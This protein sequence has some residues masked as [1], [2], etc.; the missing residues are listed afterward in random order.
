MKI[1]SNVDC[2]Q[3]LMRELTDHITSVNPYAQSFKFMYNIMKM[4]PEKQQDI[5]MFIFND[6]ANDARRYNLP[7]MTDVAAIF[8]SSDGG[9]S[10]ADRH[11]IVEPFD[12]PVKTVSTLSGTLDPLAYPLLFP[13][14]DFGWHCGMQQN[15]PRTATQKKISQ[16]KYAA[17]R[18]SVRGETDNFHLSGKLFLQ[19][20]V[21]MYV[22]IEAER[23]SYIRYHQVQLRRD[24]YSNICD[25]V[26]NEAEQ[27]HCTIGR[28]VVLPSSF[29]GSPRNMNERYQDA[30]C[31]VRRHGKPDIFITFT[32]NPN[33]KEIQE[34][35]SANEA[36]NLR[37]DIVA[38]V[39]HAK[40]KALIDDVSKNRIFGTVAALIYTI[41]FQKRGL[42]HAHILIS[43]C[44]D[45][46][47]TD[48]ATIDKYVSAEVP[49]EGDPLREIVIAHM[50][51]GP[52]GTLGC[53]GRPAPCM[54]ENGECKKGYPRD[55]A[56]ESRQHTN[57]Y[58]VY[59]R[60][61]DG[62]S[63]VKYG[64]CLDNRWIVPH[65]RYLSLK[66]NA[67]INVEICTTVKSVKYIYK[68]IYKGYDACTVALEQRTVDCDEIQ[69]FLNAR[70]V[71]SVEAAWRIFEYEMHYQ[72]AIV[73]RLN[74]HLE[75]MQSEL[76]APG[77]EAEAL[78][79]VRDSKLIAWFKLN[80]H[81]LQAR[82][83]LYTEIP[84][85]YT[86]DNKNTK[87]NPRKLSIGQRVITRLY[88]VNPKNIELFYL[89][90]IL[91]YTAGA[92]SYE[93]L[94]TYDNVTYGTY[95]DVCVARGLTA[96]DSQWRMALT[97]A[98]KSKL[99]VQIRQLFAFIVAL[100][101]PTNPTELW[102]EFKPAMSED[103]TR[104]GLSVD[105]ATNKTLCE[106]DE[107]LV[108]HNT[109]C[110]AVGLPEPNKDVLLACSEDDPLLYA[111]AFRSN[112][113]S[114]TSEQKEII[115]QVISAVLS[116]NF[117]TSK[118]F[119][120]DAPAGC[121]KTY[122]QETLRSYMRSQSRNCIAACYTGIAASLI[123]GGWTL[124]NV[125]KLPV[126]LLE[127]SVPDIDYQS[128]HAEWL[129][130]CELIIIDEASMVPSV[131]LTIIDR[132]LR[133]ITGINKPFGGKAVLLS[134]DFRQTLPVVP[135]GGRALAIEAC[136]K[137]NPVWQSVRRFNLT[138]N[139]RIKEGQDSFAAYLLDVGN[140]NLPRGSDDIPFS[141]TLQ[142]SLLGRG[143]PIDFVY[144]DIREQLD[145]GRIVNSA[146]LAP[147]NVDCAEING[148]VLDLMPGDI[149]TYVSV[150]VINSDEVGDHLN[151][152]TEFLNSLDIS[153][154]PAHQ[155]DLKKDSVVILMRNL[156]TARGL[157]NG[158]RMQ[159][160]T[161]LSHSI[162]CT[163][164]TG[165]ARGTRVLIPRIKLTTTPGVL[166]FTFTRCQIPVMVGFAMTI[167]KSQGQTFSNVGIY[168][169]LPVF[170]HG[171]LYVALSRARSL[172]K[173]KVFVEPGPHQYISENGEIIT[174][175]VVYTEVL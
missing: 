30:M 154:L 170:T 6:K 1:A 101:S 108:S 29:P 172:E 63:F 3:S 127:T 151:F 35:L 77:H 89:R 119:Y 146:I 22:R 36:A 153:G 45:N 72:S 99:P 61:N 126:P 15:N 94:R 129:R 51:H 50:V 98:M 132:L 171:Q 169:K 140:G 19:W 26:Q 115:D 54:D 79:N 134:G 59:R 130:K 16:N 74:C 2:T 67:H 40:L 64:K 21:D 91:L 9:P 138:T 87:W 70:Y 14:G 58:P 106:I 4:K 144:T 145:T 105:E 23:L 122:V 162:E 43:L 10:S 136:I 161:L 90:L 47:I 141:A 173:M 25:F 55:W 32:C 133:D 92:T 155:L 34:Q 97:E 13:F 49:Q 125:F 85:H 121:G 107:I 96:S 167:N 33:W 53:A 102:Q 60:R 104:R 168:L 123:S 131:A 20:V 111:A 37:P 27:N 147:R 18:L 56:E 109:S 116:D 69:R 160:V 103:F 158:T 41:E 88:T 11:L 44:K 149:Q 86:W 124:H 73:Y 135:H 46:K 80:Q 142:R 57:G 150:D 42:P 24:M 39:F 71:G 174:K 8:E 28:M 118:I 48:I 95:H 68:Y 7:T 112:Y 76:F 82:R 164:L 165:A 143:C 75:H 100:N 156:H 139:M 84:Q 5:R 120:L 78:K 93:D 81:D 38:R 66:Y 157:I 83:H 62:R 110:K 17:Y 117:E 163:V 175:N 166:P 52:C 159:V 114:A 148:K 113:F 31:V 137:A 152:P 128:T 65:N 12:G